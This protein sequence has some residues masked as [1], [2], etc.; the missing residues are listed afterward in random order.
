MQTTYDWR[1]GTIKSG[2]NRILGENET[3]KYLD[4][5][6]VDLIKQVEMKD[7]NQKEYLRRTR[8]LHETKL[9]SKNLIKGINTW[10]VPLV[11]Y[12]GHF[13]KWTGNEL[14]PMDKKNKKTNDH[15]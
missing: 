7:K 5:L 8:K 6:E 4:I 12:S 13:L 9:S 11:R 15:A 1:N 2:L 14:K 10:A 3:Y